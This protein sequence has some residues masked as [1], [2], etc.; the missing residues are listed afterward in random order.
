MTVD[1]LERMR[2]TGHPFILGSEC[3][4]LS[5]PGREA[6][7]ASKVDAFMRCGCPKAATGTPVCHG[8]K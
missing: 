2:L 8:I 1:L 4:V 5:V 6:E 7:I 3:D